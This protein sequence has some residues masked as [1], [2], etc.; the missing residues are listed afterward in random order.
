M[1]WTDAGA[2]GAWRFKQRLYRFIIE[3]LETAAA[4]TEAEPTEFTDSALALRRET[5]KT[6]ASVTDSIEKLH[7][8]TAIARIYEFMKALGEFKPSSADDK[9]ALREAMTVMVSIV[10]PMMPHLAEELWELLGNTEILADSP[11]PVAIEELTVDNRVTIA[12]QVK[13]KLRGTIEV[14]KDEDASKVEAMALEEE[15]VKRFIGDTTIRKVIV[16]PNRI[17]NIVI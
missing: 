3:N 1:E 14:S 2:T 9:W 6:L 7:F 16:V 5:H 11:W 12:V 10:G 4:N 8:N 15:N 17:V 13:G